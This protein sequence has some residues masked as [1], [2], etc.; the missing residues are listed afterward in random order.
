VGIG[1]IV[2]VFL[3][4]VGFLSELLHVLDRLTS[5][6]WNVLVR[7]SLSFVLCVV[8]CSHECMGSLFVMNTRCLLPIHSGAV[9]V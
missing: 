6:A 3:V 8:V 5:C 7:A 4:F 9:A 2:L 1:S